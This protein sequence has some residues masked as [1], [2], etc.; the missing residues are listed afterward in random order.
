MMKR[1]DTNGDG[2]V[3]DEERAAAIKQFQQ[4]RGGSGAPGGK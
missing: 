3:S 1:F 4:S 2:K